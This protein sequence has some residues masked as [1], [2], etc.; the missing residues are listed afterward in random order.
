MVLRGEESEAL[1]ARVEPAPKGASSSIMDVITVEQHGREWS[2]RRDGAVLSLHPSRLE[3][4]RAAQW[5]F[6]H[7]PQVAERARV[8]G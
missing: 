7:D 4:E 1:L 5:L 6:A 2:V 3:A 8:G